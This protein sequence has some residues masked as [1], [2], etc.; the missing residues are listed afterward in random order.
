MQRRGFIESE[1]ERLSYLVH[2]GY[3]LNNPKIPW[4]YIATHG[5]RIEGDPKAHVRRL[6]HLA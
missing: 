4:H 1:I 5:I 3:T 2:R 6:Q